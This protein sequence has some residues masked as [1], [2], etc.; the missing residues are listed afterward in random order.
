MVQLWK[1][2]QSV[3]LLPSFR[4]ICLLQ[5]TNFVLQ[6]R[7]VVNELVRMKMCWWMDQN[8]RRYVRELSRFTFGSQRKNL[9]LWAIARKSLKNHKTV[10][11]GGWMLPMTIR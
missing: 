8:N 7:N 3:T 6:A 1:A 5:Y 2:D 4:S 9:A 11:I 10:K